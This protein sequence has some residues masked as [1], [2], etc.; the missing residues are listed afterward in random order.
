MTHDRGLRVKIILYLRLSKYS[1]RCHNQSQSYISIL[2]HYLR[3]S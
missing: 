1:L 3:R 2:R